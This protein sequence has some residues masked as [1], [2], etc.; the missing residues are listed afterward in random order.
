MELARAGLLRCPQGLRATGPAALHARRG[1]EAAEAMPVRSARAREGLLLRSGRPT[2]YGGNRTSYAVSDSWGS[3]RRGQ[4]MGS[5]MWTFPVGNTTS[6]TGFELL[7][8]H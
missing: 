8:S 1:Q 2:F 3:G 6:A 5:R 7:F 4:F